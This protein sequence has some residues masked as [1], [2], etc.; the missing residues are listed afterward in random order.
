MLDCAVLRSAKNYKQSSSNSTLVAA[1]A[2]LERA[3]NFRHFEHRRKNHPLDC[4]MRFTEL[5]HS[6]GE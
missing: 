5:K 4:S 3:I 6:G 2:E 1:A